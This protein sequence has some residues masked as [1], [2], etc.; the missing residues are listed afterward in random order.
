VELWDGTRYP[1]RVTARHPGRDLAALRIAATG[2]EP[3]RPDAPDSLRPGELVMAAGNPLGFVGALS[4]GVVHSIGP[5]PGMGRERWIR[6]DVRLAPG[7]SGGPLANA[8]GEVVGIN[9]AI[10]NGLGAAVPVAAV[11]AFLEHGSPPRLGVT[12]R[13]VRDGLLILEVEPGGAAERSSLQLGDIL[14]MTYDELHA[15]LDAGREVLRLRFL[16]GG[17]AVRETHVRL[18]TRRREAA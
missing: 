9:T 11:L 13:P 2:L 5:L 1:A 18:D 14:V 8:R 3:A 17:G 7:N 15:E 10:V 12:L 4:T 6:A 16:R